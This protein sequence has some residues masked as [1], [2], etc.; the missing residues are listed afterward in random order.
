MV[1]M[2]A[3]ALGIGTM[4][5]HRSA[6]A[7]EVPSGFDATVLVTNLNAATTLTV[8]SDGRIFLAEQ[9]G[10]IRLWK[11]G[12]IMDR[13]VIELLVTD[14]WERGLIGLALDPDFPRNPHLY[15]L[16][17]VAEPFVHH[18]LS[19]FDLR[20]DTADP[21]SERILLRGDDQATMGG[22]QPAGHQGG[23][24][25]FGSDGCLYVAIGE[26]TASEPSQ[27]LDTFLGKILRLDPDGSIPADNPF[28]SQTSGKYRAIYAVGIRNA[29][30]LALQPETGRMFFTD[31]GG[32]AFEEVNELRA[33]A[34]YGWPIAEGFSNE[35]GLTL[36]L[37]AYPP[38]VGRSIV[39]GL[40]Y[41]RGPSDDS[42][43]PER[44]R[45]RFFF[46]DFMNHWVRAMDPDAPTNVVTF[47]RG[48]NGPVAMAL[49][50]DG[51]L[52]VL[53]RGT[54][55][56]DP[57]RFVRDSGSLVRI[58]YSTAAPVAKEADSPR[59]LAA[60][61]LPG[62]LDAL[63]QRLSETAVAKL[64]CDK[65]PGPM[66]RTEPVAL[67]VP[68][69]EP[70][71]TERIWFALPR[72]SRIGFHPTDDWSIPPGA[73]VVRHFETGTRPLETR[74]VVAGAA[75]GY[76]ASYRWQADGADALLVEDFDL[77]D[78]A[79]RGGKRARQ[80]FFP[81]PEAH[82]ALPATGTAYAL[83]L[84]T[85]QLNRG[86]SDGPENQLVRWRRLGLLDLPD[87]LSPQVLPRMAPLDDA[88]ASLEVRVRSY[89][90]ANCAGCHQPG[91]NSR[92]LF[93]ARFEAPLEGAGLIDGALAA[94]DLGIAGARV[95][96][97]GDPERSILLRRIT[98]TDFFRMPPV[99][100]HEEP[101][102][103]VPLLTDWI[104]KLR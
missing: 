17:V 7:Q 25:A 102:P 10:V 51:S 56:R 22:F 16:C 38:S 30:G 82:L 69:W 100:S 43:F 57:R 27:R 11:D 60:F 46:A 83:P 71:V 49:E 104:R 31:V 63:P 5:P 81:A 91:G 15:I 42:A 9:T 6:P 64:V 28:H 97:P 103:V 24:L 13:P 84:N 68:R 58:R 95:I 65:L 33:G 96:A 50:P 98:A 37:H 47:G 90:D 1:S 78:V 93:D 67:N 79:F 85:R 12:G 54:I 76:G 36:P 88:S 80:W 2:A 53:N 55:W 21:A 73:V 92:G 14:Y 70:G 75:H 99:A 87:T 19:R 77:A 89:L 66:P 29:Y 74:I 45:G 39:G 23:P 41:P 34:N 4:L 72:E 86:A 32:T 59:P 3:A 26:Q 48:F 40:F 8:A 44:W 52:L 62:R 94:G 61:G 101:S 20:G 35:P 18:V